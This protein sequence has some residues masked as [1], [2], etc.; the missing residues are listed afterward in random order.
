MYRIFFNIIILLNSCYDS[1]ENEAVCEIWSW[2][3][4]LMGLIDNSIAKGLGT[5]L[6]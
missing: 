4:G 1:G 3:S 2:G 5:K 6:P